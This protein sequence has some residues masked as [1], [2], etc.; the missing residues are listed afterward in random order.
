MKPFFSLVSRFQ[1]HQARVPSLSAVVGQNHLC[2]CLNTKK[3]LVSAIF[4]CFFYVTKPIRSSHCPT[5]AHQEVIWIHGKMNTWCKRGRT[6]KQVNKRRVQESLP[7]TPLAETQ[8]TIS[9]CVFFLFFF[10]LQS[11]NTIKTVSLNNNQP[12]RAGMKQR[13]WGEMKRNKAGFFFCFSFLKH[14]HYPF[15]STTF[16]DE[17]PTPT[18]HS[19]CLPCCSYLQTKGWSFSEKVGWEVG[20]GSGAASSWNNRQLWVEEEPSPATFSTVQLFL[21][22]RLPRCPREESDGE[23]PRSSRLLP[24]LAIV[25]LPAAFFFFFFFCPS[26]KMTKL[27]LLL[28]LNEYTVFR[29]GGLAR[30]RYACSVGGKKRPIQ[31]RRS[32]KEGWRREGGVVAGGW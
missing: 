31:R 2:F 7:R 6:K 23:L 26:P 13:H 21:T 18:L 20:G 28:I 12:H 30:L 5:L 19:K 14:S 9:N 1:L 16:H 15:Q 27:S 4:V 17:M 11:K 32:N 22:C 8:R 29:C 24:V 10:L 25:L 3:N